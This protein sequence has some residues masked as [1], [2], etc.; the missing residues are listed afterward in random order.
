MLPPTQSS[1]RSNHSVHTWCGW[2]TIARLHICL[3]LVSSKVLQWCKL[4]CMSPHRWIWHPAWHLKVESIHQNRHQTW[5]NT[6]WWEAHFWKR[7]LPVKDWQHNWHKPEE[8]SEME[9]AAASQWHHQQ[10]LQS[11]LVSVVV[12]EPHHVD[13]MLLKPHQGGG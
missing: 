2:L 1:R 3:Q 10:H 5:K 7:N 6:K 8:A 13:P 4:K 9:V 11:A 12:A